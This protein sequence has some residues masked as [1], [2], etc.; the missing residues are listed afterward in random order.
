MDRNLALDAVRVTEAAALACARYMGR[1]D[2]VAV[3]KAAVDAMRDAV[4]S[5]AIDGTVVIGEGPEEAMGKLF[6]G[7]RVGTGDGRAVEVA[8]DA[9]EGA[10]A[11]ATGG[12]NAL[13]AIV[14]G[15]PGALLR[16]PD[17]YMEKLACG[18]AGR[19]IVSLH[20]PIEE[21]LAALAK[22]RGVYLEQLTVAVL[23]RPRHDRLIEQVRRAGARI[24][25]ITDGDLAA[26]LATARP[27]SGIDLLV[28]TGRA[29][30]GVLAAA[31]LRCMSG[32]MQARFAPRNEH[33]AGLLRAAG[34]YD[35]TRCYGIDE[36]VSGNV[37]L[38][39]TGVTTGD[40]LAGVRYVQ[41]GAVTH[42]IVMRS[43]SHTMRVIE[44]HHHF[45]REPVYAPAPERPAH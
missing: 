18:P 7:E 6:D 43:A 45:D 4:D 39:A 16:A 1:G 11:C 10:A 3:D 14:L 32:E 31:G 17:T 35:F 38:A 9:V 36:L 37:M 8:I 13:S 19:G 44:A 30:Q 33:E 24:K 15:D 34:H 2:H 23:D 20:R 21:N 5:I 12:V 41:G 25:L 28:G 40:F 29:P 26:A 27:E 42:S 22:A